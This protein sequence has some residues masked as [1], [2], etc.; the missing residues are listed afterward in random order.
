MGYDAQLERQYCYISKITYKDQN[1]LLVCDQSSSVGV[2]QCILQV[3]MFSGYDFYATLVNT[4]T[5]THKE[6]AF[7]RL[8]Y[9]RVI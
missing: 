2:G 4:Q 1:D 3:P 5:H 6:T 7:D 8:H 9:I